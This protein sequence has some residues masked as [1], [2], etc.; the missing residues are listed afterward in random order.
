M[1]RFKLIVEYDGAPFVGWQRQKNGR[2]VQET[3]E[4]AIRSFCGVEATTFAAGRT[5]SGVHALAMPVHFD[6][7]TSYPV[8][9]V[10]DAINHFLRP[11]PAAVLSAEYVSDDFHAR[12]SAIA[13]HYRYRIVNRRAP[14]TLDQGKAWWIAGSLNAAAMH[15]GAQALVGR[16]DFSTFRAARCQAASPIK[17]MTTLSVARAGEEIAID[18]SAPSFLHNQVR[19]IAGTLVQ[20]GLGR[21]RGDAVKEALEAKNRTAC[22]P[23]APPVGLYFVRADYDSA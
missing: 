11:L 16:H 1:Q 7:P 6:L 17:A 3:L 21:W 22:G 4:D 8:E 5:D 18:V 15:E 9:T 12:F 10:R 20:V 23:V 13:R 2:S 19:S 14:L